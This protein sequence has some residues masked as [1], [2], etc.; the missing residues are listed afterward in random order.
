M[1]YSLILLFFLCSLFTAAQDFET[2]LEVTRYKL[3]PKELNIQKDI[4]VDK[5]NLKVY[6]VREGSIISDYR[7]FKPKKNEILFFYGTD[8]KNKTSEMFFKFGDKLKHVYKKK[9][10]NQLIKIIEILE[11]N[12]FS[13]E[14]FSGS[15][16]Y[17]ALE[18]A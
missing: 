16:A 10:F 6:H 2:P 1:K 12:V 5:I 14:A 4:T 3:L 8:T 13:K 7:F 11:Y 15:K 9:N 18:R 17:A